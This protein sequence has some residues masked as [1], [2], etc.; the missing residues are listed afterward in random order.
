MLHQ[1]PETEK[2]SSVDR[3]LSS[4]LHSVA[5]SAAF[6]LLVSDHAAGQMRLCDA[7]RFEV[8]RVLRT[9]NVLTVEM[10]ADGKERWRVVGEDSDARRIEA[11]VELLPP[12]LAILV[13]V[14]G[15]KVTFRVRRRRD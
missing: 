3:D 1:A 4:W 5:R 6:R 12:A 13:A 15:R 8:E 9:G 2:H 11:V 14:T 7:S 10:D